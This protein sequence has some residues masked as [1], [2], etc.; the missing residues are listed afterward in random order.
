MC[1]IIGIASRNPV[2]GRAWLAIGRDQLA[3]RGPDDAGE[4]WSPDG[5]VGLGHRRL[6]I[7]DLSSRGHQPMLDAEG[8]LAI[9]FNG[10]IY[11][12]LDLRAELVQRGHRFFSDSDTETILRSFREWGVECLQRL[13]GMFAFAL[14]DLRLGQLLLARD[15][16]GEKPLY[17]RLADGAVRFASELKGLYADTSL[18]RRLDPQSFDNYLWQG[19]VGGERCIL[20]GFNKLPPAHALLFD[21]DSGTA[22]TWRYW[23]LPPLADT[24]A[25]TTENA[26]LEELE[27]LLQDSVRRQLVADVPVGVLLSGGVDSSLVTAMAARSTGRVKTFT[28]RFPGHARYD[29]THHARLIARHFATQHLE[30]EASSVIPE[31][32][33]AL[34]QQYDEPLIDS[35]VLPT[36]MVSSLVRQ[37]CKV[38]LGGDGGDELF[39]GYAHYSRLVWMNRALGWA[40]QPLRNAA[41]GLAGCLPV[42][43]KGRNWVQA[44]GTDLHTEVPLVAVYFEAAAR[45]RLLSCRTHLAHATGASL[46]SRPAGDGDLVQRC[47]RL[48]FQN[49]L[50]ED[51]L[52]KVDR[53]SMLHSLEVRAPM[54]DVR[55]IEFAFGKVPSALKADR[56]RRKILLKKL[57]ARVL[58]PEF[59]MQRKQGFSIPLASWLR[60]ADWNGFFR[61]V[62][63]DEGQRLFAHRALE[64][65]LDGIPTRPANSERL[66]GL[67]MFELWRRAYDI[68]IGA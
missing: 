23:Q 4:W 52:V 15:R 34:A 62:L 65:M 7:L 24:A 6:A 41:A 26:L 33:T 12:H 55:L 11:N 67:V 2:V 14:L 8:T 35:S 64:K 29:E 31:A 66:F 58:P 10:E 20:A 40:P 5:L 18:P 38:A 32:L 42:G 21:L 44:L 56:A 30:L 43:V 22:R 1:G 13:R 50:A 59:D 3:H 9:V 17:Y 37:H 45:R 36:S 28:V 39:G 57:A 60:T 51:I 16:A 68:D 48:D 49:Y 53:A 47:T 46:D 61:E 25:A 54:L 63:L 27:Q 19:F